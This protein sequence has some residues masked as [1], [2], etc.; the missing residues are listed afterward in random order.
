MLEELQ[1][2]LKE[3]A[4]KL[5][6]ETNNLKAQIITLEDA[7]EREESRCIIVYVILILSYFIFFYLILISVGTN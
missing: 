5:D 4:L 7:I 2:N 3:T 1:H 6:E